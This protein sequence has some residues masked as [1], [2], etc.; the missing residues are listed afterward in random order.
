[1]S[2]TA[3]VIFSYPD[4]KLFLPQTLASLSKQSDQDFDVI[5]FNDGLENLDVICQD[6]LNKTPYIK[7]ISGNI[8]AIRSN[9][10]SQ[11]KKSGYKN[12]IFGDAD[13]VF[14]TN[15]IEVSKKLLT[16]YDVA[17]NDLDICN[18]NLTQ[19]IPKYFRNRIAS[20]TILNAKAIHKSNCIGFTNSAL[21]AE[22]I[23]ELEFAQNLIAID[24]AFFTFILRGKSRAYFTSRTST[25]YRIHQKSYYDVTSKDPST[26]LFQVNAKQLHY[27]YLA[28]YFNEYAQLSEEF[29]DLQQKL[30][31][32]AFYESYKREMMA[33][34]TEFPFWWEGAKLVNEETNPCG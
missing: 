9:G 3:F 1:M 29:L 2:K 12:I 14:S 20:D 17:V 34:Q 7:P 27:H 19:T 8:E 32:L 15:R 21:R 24:W 28:K 5:I 30:K 4:C 11:M 16:K 25:K 33:L 23:P 31:D 10:L 22:V 18:E 13:D 6:F 26:L